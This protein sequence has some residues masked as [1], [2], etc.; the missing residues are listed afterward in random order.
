M[1]WHILPGAE[2]FN[3][4]LWSVSCWFWH[5]FT[6]ADVQPVAV[7]FWP[8]DSLTT[9]HHIDQV[10]ASMLANRLLSR[11]IG[12]QVGGGFDSSTMRH[13]PSCKHP[14]CLALEI[15]KQVNLKLFYTGM[16]LIYCCLTG[17]W[18]DLSPAFS[19]CYFGFMTGP[20][21][22]EKL[23]T[24]SSTLKKKKKENQTKQNTTLC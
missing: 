21:L 14:A 1:E 4:V 11:S 17:Q 8:A 2:P 6:L 9:D 23:A 5:V 24:C 19:C 16:V 3:V 20:D 10:S 18:P 22:S 12:A 13:L 15:N 7:G